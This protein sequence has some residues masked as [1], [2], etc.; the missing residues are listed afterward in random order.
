MALFVSTP[1][2]SSSYRC[3]TDYILAVIANINKN[4]TKHFSNIYFKNSS[5]WSLTAPCAQ[6]F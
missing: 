2:L 3:F 1:C 5:A 6:F 4:A